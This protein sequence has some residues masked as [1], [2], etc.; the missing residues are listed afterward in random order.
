MLLLMF[1]I[2]L[3]LVGGCLFGIGFFRSTESARVASKFDTYFQKHRHMLN[4]NLSQLFDAPFDLQVLVFH[5]VVSWVLVGSLYGLTWLA[6]TWHI[7]EAAMA[8]NILGIIMLLIVALLSSTCRSKDD[9]IFVF[10]HPVFGFVPLVIAVP[11]IFSMFITFTP[12][13]RLLGS[14]LLVLIVYFA[15][16]LSAFLSWFVSVYVRLVLILIGTAL[17]TTG[18]LIMVM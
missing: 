5:A 12:V 15:F 11:F 9:F 16:I 3:Q 4:L 8:T 13:F 1:G 2:L 7:V 14:A 17:Y 18:T 10:A 6:A